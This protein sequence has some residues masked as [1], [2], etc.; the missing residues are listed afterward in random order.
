MGRSLGPV[1]VTHDP[2]ICRSLVLVPRDL[3]HAFVCY[4]SAKMSKCVFEPDDLQ[5]IV[6]MH[7]D[8]P[9]EQR[10]DRIAETLHDVYGEHIHPGNEWIWSNAG[11]I[12]CSMNVLHNSPKEYLLFCGTAVGSEGH[13]GRHRAELYDIVVHGEL[14]TFRPNQFKATT[15]KPGDVS[16]LPRQTTNGSHLSKECWLLEYARGNI[17][18]MFPFA[19]GD[20]LFSTQ[21]LT[22][23]RKTMVHS[24]RLM[25][26]EAKLAF[27][28]KLRGGDGS[29]PRL[30]RIGAPSSSR[31]QTADEDSTLN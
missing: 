30:D 12:M 6:Q 25:W 1:H 7:L 22:D 4:R 27:R 16:H 18:S 23:L 26:S 17:L 10:L 29:A 3:S 11:G 14:Q 24:T 31:P 21:D 2:P 28:G 19:L 15:L 13:S 8:V 5:R 20:T 9:L